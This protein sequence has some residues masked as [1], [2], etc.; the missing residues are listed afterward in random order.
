[1]LSCRYSTPGTIP[2]ER[3]F[4][5][6]ERVQQLT[7]CGRHATL[8]PFPMVPYAISL[9]LS[10]TWRALKDCPQAVDD[11][12]SGITLLQDTLQELGKWSPKAAEMSRLGHKLMRALRAPAANSTTPV[13][14]ANDHQQLASSQRLLEDGGAGDEPSQGVPSALGRVSDRTWESATTRTSSGGTLETQFTDESQPDTTS[15]G[16]DEM[17]NALSLGFGGNVDGFEALMA[18]GIFDFSHLDATNGGDAF[19][20]YL[21]TGKACSIGGQYAFADL[22]PSTSVSYG[23]IQ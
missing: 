6:A 7:S 10:V 14:K 18:P 19:G 12:M 2:Y 15:A 17:Y 8:P 3:R 22:N 1:M 9:S 21:D 16:F 13:L 11:L 4:R 5:S 23:S 20:H